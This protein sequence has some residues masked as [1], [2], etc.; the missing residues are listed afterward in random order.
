MAALSRMRPDEPQRATQAYPVIQALRDTLQDKPAM[1]G[2]AAYAAHCWELMALWAWLPAFMAFA[3]KG[4]GMSTAQGIG[5][6]AGAHL[7]SMAGSLLGGAASDRFGR[8]PVMLLASCASL[9]CSFSFGWMEKVPLWLL[10]GFGAWYSLCAIA[11]SSV[12]S[13][14]LADVVPASRLGAAFSVR[15][16]M[17]FGAG[18]VSPWVFGLASDWGQSHFR[19]QGL[20][21]RWHGAVPDWGLSQDLG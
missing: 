6:A 13:T 7:V 4:G 8:A 11:D 9:L 19:R 3:A 10:A 12:H 17:G 20:G 14:A 15:S 16:V 18:A 5:L 2:S 21:G 1:T